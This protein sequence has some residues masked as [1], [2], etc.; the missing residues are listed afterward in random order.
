MLEY[1]GTGRLPRPAPVVAGRSVRPP[2][3]LRRF[4]VVEN[5]DALALALDCAV[6]TW[7]VFLHPAQQ[8]IVDRSYNGPARTSGSAGTGKTVVA[9]HRA[10]RLA[11]RRPTAECC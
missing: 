9:L 10:A 4:R 11:G 7:A 5:Q 3:A 2:D 8:G 1:V 6:G